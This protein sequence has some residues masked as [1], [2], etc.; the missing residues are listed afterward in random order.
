MKVMKKFYVLEMKMVTNCKKKLMTS[1]IQ[2][3]NEQ[4]RDHM[5]N[6]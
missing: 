2:L 1:G 4:D 6:E 5:L 3:L